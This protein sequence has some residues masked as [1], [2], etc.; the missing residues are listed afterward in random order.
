M[1]LA[2][3]PGVMEIL[4]AVREAGEPLAVTLARVRRPYPGLTEPAMHAEIKAYM[5]WLHDRVE[6][7]SALARELAF[8]MTVREMVR[9]IREAVDP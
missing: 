9:E 4:E 1:R 5:A 8:E 6:K 7:Q 2:P 3:K